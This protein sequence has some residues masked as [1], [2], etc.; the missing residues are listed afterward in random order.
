MNEH[1]TRIS[2]LIIS[3]SLF[4]YIMYIGKGGKIIFPLLLFLFYLL[5]V[6]IIY[7]LYELFNINLTPYVGNLGIKITPKWFD[8]M[9]WLLIIG[10]ISFVAKKT[11]D[12]TILIIMYASYLLLFFY[13]YGIMNKVSKWVYE[14]NKLTGKTKVILDALNIYGGLIIVIMLYFLIDMIV[15]KLQVSS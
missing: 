2:L 14:K 11:A 7:F 12:S 1:I 10:A 5:S 3:M 6:A 15:T 13:I 8:F 9:K 4:S